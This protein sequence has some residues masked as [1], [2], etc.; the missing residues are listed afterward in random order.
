[1]KRLFFGE[2]RGFRGR[3]QTTKTLKPKLENAHETS[4]IPSLTLGSCHEVLYFSRDDERDSFI[5]D[6]DKCVKMASAI[7]NTL[8]VAI[9]QYAYSLD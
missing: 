9:I 1:M 8:R 5:G 2:R 6:T 3:R 4:L 7:V